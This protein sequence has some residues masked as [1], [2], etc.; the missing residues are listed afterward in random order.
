MHESGTRHSCD[1]LP[2]VCD[3]AVLLYRVQGLLVETAHYYYLLGVEQGHRRM[4]APPSTQIGHSHPL[5][6]SLLVFLYR[7]E[8]FQAVKATDCIDTVG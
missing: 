3:K 8:V 4:G 6:T 5:R 2:L 1:L 7:A